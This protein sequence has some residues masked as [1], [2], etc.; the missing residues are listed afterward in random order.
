MA[1]GGRGGLYGGLKFSSTNA[2]A[3]ALKADEAP[4][5]QDESTQGA[6]VEAPIN[7]TAGEREKPN[8]NSKTGASSQKASTGWSAALAFAPVRRGPPKPKPKQA[9]PL[10]PLLG[11]T[12]VPTISATAVISAEPVLITPQQ[13]PRQADA[14]ETVPDKQESKDGWAK[15]IKPP[16][17]VLDDDVNGF[18]ST[19]RQGGG[20]GG[21]K[22]GK[23]AKFQPNVWDPFEM[24]DPTRPNDYGEYKA[25][26]QKDKMETRMRQKAEREGHRYYG[27]GSAEYTD[28]GRSDNDDDTGDWRTRKSAQ[29]YSPPPRDRDYE[30][31]DYRPGLG[32]GSGFTSAAMP[33]TGDEAYQRRMALSAGGPAP[34]FAPTSVPLVETG[35][36]AYQ[37][38]LALSSGF[39]PSSTTTSAPAPPIA[40]P[41]DLDGEVPPPTP[42]P[43]ESAAPAVDSDTAKIL[44][45]RKEAAAAIAAR[46]AQVAASTHASGPPD[47]LECVPSPFLDF[48]IGLGSSGSSGLVEPLTVEQAK[49]KAKAP[50]FKA[51]ATQF[52]PATSAGPSGIGAGAGGINRIINSNPEKGK[53]ERERWGEPS[54]IVVLTNIVG[55]E[56]L[57]DED[58]REDIGAECSKHGVVERVIVHA[59]DPLPAEPELHVRIFV[60]FSGPVGAWKTV[61]ELD[62]RFFGGRTVRAQ[63]Y[64][65][66]GFMKYQLNGQI[67]P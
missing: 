60:Q 56:D 21:K 45:Q 46:L 25:W 9:A 66:P 53:E 2:P 61:R 58:L 44:Q 59:V 39:V 14:E 16:S 40:P 54:R 42:P 30:R 35:D 17:M 12:A 26:K 65:E 6:S 36:E 50:K 19:K 63:Y 48:G 18:R 33:E 64:P 51:G 4:S 10:L 15:R 32:G 22:K 29:Y 41:E 11:F 31:D 37:R 57:D 13:Q 55:L 8:D 20:G 23:K 5:P 34:S 62:G 49:A 7:P 27:E 3:T 67:L 43:E 38:R 24:Y 28:E 47:S 1:S 52:T